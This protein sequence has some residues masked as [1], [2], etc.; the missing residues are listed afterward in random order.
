[1]ETSIIDLSWFCF[2]V[3]LGIVLIVAVFGARSRFRYAK[4]IR[5]AQKRGAFEDMNTP[6]QKNRFRWGALA[7]LIGVVGVMSS[8]VAL[9]L[10]RLGV[11]P[12]SIGIVFMSLGLFGT[13]AV[14]AG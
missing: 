10:Q 6:K 14:I 5:E 7:A 4:R 11:I 2:V 8:L 3:P 1:M 9:V 12:L 13:R